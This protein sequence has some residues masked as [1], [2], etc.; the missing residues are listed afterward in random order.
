MPHVIHLISSNFFGGPER[1]ILGLSTH[2]SFG[3]R[4][5]LVV[6]SETG[7]CH[8]LQHEAWRKGL[9]CYTLSD[10]F[11]GTFSLTE[12]LK[13]VIVGLDADVLCC[14][15]YKANLIG[16]LAARSLD[17]PFVIIL[18]GWT[19]E[20]LK[21]R[22]YEMLDRMT[23]TKMDLVVCLSRAQVRDVRDAGVAVENIRLIPNAISLER[24]PQPDYFPKSYE[25]RSLAN[26]TKF[27]CCSAGRLSPEKGFVDLVYVARAAKLKNLPINFVLFGEGPLR[28]LLQRIITRENLGQQIVLSGFSS[29]LDNILPSCDILLIPSYTEG[30]PN[31]LLEGLSAGV[32]VVGTRVGGIPDLITDGSNGFLVQ[33]GDVQAMA[34]RIELLVKDD[35]LR[36]SFRQAGRSLIEKDY[37]FDLQAERYR[38]VFRDIFERASLNNLST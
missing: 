29:N 6:F 27:V 5:T 15:G 2:L 24:F 1:Q 34:D 33:P 36:F 22:M 4:N 9:S 3:Y 18:R 32:A 11:S 23:L 21:V 19:G 14:H 37:S 28:P 26:K 31:V 10:D 35:Q 16:S 20:D 8:A 17:L 12:E 7:N 30:I 13:R 25:N 38:A